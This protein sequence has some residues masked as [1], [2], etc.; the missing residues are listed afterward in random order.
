MAELMAGLTVPAILSGAYSA[1]RTAYNL[2]DAT[3][4]RREQVR[5][6][7]SR[8]ED[9]V[10]ETAKWAQSHAHLS[11]DVLV[12]AQ[13][14][15]SACE[16]VKEL[17]EN[18]N[19]KGFVWCLLNADKIDGQVQLSREKIQDAFTIFEFHAHFDIAS[20]QADLVRAQIQDKGDLSA[21]LYKLAENDR[22]ILDAIQDQSGVYKRLEDLL[23]GV[24]KHVQHIPVTDD[25]TP[26]NRFL[27]TAADALGRRYNISADRKFA[28]YIL[29]S[30]EVEEIQGGLIGSGATGQVFTGEWRGSIVAIKRMHVQDARVINDKDRRTLRHEVK[31]W[32][33]LHH[34]NIL[35]LYGA[36]PDADVSCDV[37]AN[38][39]VNGEHRALL[40]DF[41]LSVVMNDIRSRSTYS[42][43]LQDK[44]RGTMAWMAPE[45]H[46][47]S[48][49]DKA[50]DVYSLAMTIWEIF[51]EKNPFSGIRLEALSDVVRGGT[52]PPQL[53]G[54]P[55]GNK[56]WDIVKDCWA[57]DPKSRPESAEVMTR[58]KRLM[59]TEIP[60]GF[61]GDSVFDPLSK[62]SA[63][64]RNSEYRTNDN[65][66]NSL[67]TISWATAK[68][69]RESTAS[70]SK[71]SESRNI[72]S[73]PSQVSAK[74]TSSAAESST[75]DPKDPV[76][77][78]I[79][80]AFP[81]QW[82]YVSWG[83]RHYVDEVTIPVV[84]I[85]K[86]YKYRIL[87][88]GSDLGIRDAYELSA[89]GSQRI[90]FLEYNKGYGII[91]SMHI[92]V[93]VVDPDGNEAL[94]AY[95]NPR[96]K[97][98]TN[99]ESEYARQVRAS[100]VRWIADNS[101]VSS[102]VLKRVLNDK[103]Y[104]LRVLRD[105]VDLGVRP[106]SPLTAD[107]SLTIDLKAYNGGQGIPMQSL[108]K[109]LV[110]DSDVGGIGVLVTGWWQPPGVDPNLLFHSRAP[111]V[112]YDSKSSL[113][114]PTALSRFPSSSSALDKT[115]STPNLSSASSS[116]PLFV[117][118][119][120]YTPPPS[121]AQIPD[122][123]PAPPAKKRHFWRPWK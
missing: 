115:S 42:K 64:A 96:D 116:L 6:M 65:S 122:G 70:H 30:F 66:S 109:L 113:N 81:P 34:E 68:D 57:G 7:L 25:L 76:W 10:T 31:I 90:N 78:S 121:L 85:D 39:L 62:I 67:T 74:G 1:L 123:Q 44:A 119:V 71:Q 47:G 20:F 77:T 92:K 117:P 102:V 53:P 3:K 2:Y 29:S 101:L 69:T 87:S 73:S 59:K 51:N 94:V 91:D 80:Q 43:E 27:R 28:A 22:Q 97:P 15:Q 100:G 35:P 110:V 95:W 86:Q 23:I 52:R 45:V 104:M 4:S 11:E 93:F 98:L 58:L 108:I 54:F 50:A 105:D 107:K 61:F 18:L 16:S 36:C 13:R 8:C 99:L 112:S 12:G 40:A 111:R 21:L 38:V 17:I 56:V 89:D 82:K 60:S 118:S 72:H 114:A 37:A 55:E 41:G 9:L 19:K 83:A 88:G 5:L 63:A 33:T 106:A 14:I 75:P 84:L 26:E 49:P 120:S 46:S 32:A 24:Y 79:V 103:D 48:Q